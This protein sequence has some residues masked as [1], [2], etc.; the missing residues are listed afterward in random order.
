M[1]KI[2]PLIIISIVAATF[3]LAVS[4]LW[5][6]GDESAIGH[7]EQAYIVEEI[8]VG[9]E[10]LNTYKGN[11]NFSLEREIAI[12]LGANPYKEDRLASFPRIDMQ[13]GS[14]IKLFRAPMYTVIDGNQSQ[15][16]RSWQKS[17]GELLN[18]KD[19]VLGKEDKI[20]FATNFEL[21]PDMVVKIIRVARTE[22]VEEET[23]D[24]KIIEK[25]DPELDRGKTRVEQYGEKG[26]RALTYE[27]IRENG[28][29]ISKTLL[30]DEV[31]KEPVNTVKYYGTKVTVLSSHKGDATLTNAYPNGIVSP[32]YSRGTL[33]RITN[34]DNGKRVEGTVTHTWGLTSAPYGVVLD[35]GIN[36]WKQ[37]GY[38]NSFG[39]G[40]YVLV[41]ELKN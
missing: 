1:S 33:L 18:E 12:D 26:T 37:L 17:V 30:R 8:D 24:Y 6:K 25:A 23:I 10:V 21:E 11:S 14:K 5:A 3:F 2:I 29:E 28:V 40:P 7:F 31:T 41:E 19:I 35:V 13:I 36:I 38:D 4:S 20:N 39:R 9:G 15:I 16:Y 34:L 22:L 27:V 32:N